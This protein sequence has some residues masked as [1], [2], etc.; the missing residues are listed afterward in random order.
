ME[1]TRP[2]PATAPQQTRAQVCRGHCEAHSPWSREKSRS[3]AAATADSSGGTAEAAAVA[4]APS[5]GATAS[6]EA[7]VPEPAG[8]GPSAGPTASVEEA[9]GTAQGERSEPRFVYENPTLRIRPKLRL[10]EEATED[11]TVTF[12]VVEG[13]SENILSVNRAVDEGA[14]VW[15]SADE[16][17]IL[18]PDGGKAT[19][20]RQGKQFILPFEEL[21]G[22]HRQ[23]QIAHINEDDEDAQAVRDW[24]MQHDEEAEAVLE[25]AQREEE[26][27]QAEERTKEDPGLLA[28][29]EAEGEPPAAPEA[30]E[31]GLPATPSEDEMRRHR[32]THLPFAPWC[33][34]CV[35]GK[36]REDHHK[37]S[38]TQVVEHKVQ[39]DYL[40]SFD[41]TRTSTNFFS[42]GC[43]DSASFTAGGSA[44]E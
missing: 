23:T 21:S 19:F 11:A 5:A 7:E 42:W 26:A 32:L 31:L 14:G 10:G 15:F 2:E 8:D 37:Q 38:N 28:D 30:Q 3:R 4:E 20:S 27:R 41:F 43:I 29:L 36:A 22:R 16:C 17:Y 35:S 13:I 18:W 25:Y 44:R 39:M 9:G 33:E 24:E 6:H 1:P 12:Q 34:E 40:F